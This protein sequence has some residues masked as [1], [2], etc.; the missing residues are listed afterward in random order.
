LSRKKLDPDPAVR[1]GFNQAVGRGEAKARAKLAK[2]PK[3]KDALFALT[4]SSGLQGD[5]AALI[6]KR[7]LLSLHFAKQATGWA[8]QLL[9]VDPACSDAHVATGFSKYI[10]GSMS[11]PFRWLVRMGGISG[12]KKVGISE[13]ELTAQTGHYLAPFARILLAI[14]Y[15]REKDNSHARELLASL[16]D[17]FP[18]NPLFAYEIAHLDSLH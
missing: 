4:L 5:Y 6:D 8:E 1:D 16:R 14:A 18:A 10:I 17:Q 7:N 3:D 12:D 9:A 11:A 2:N 13:L 15:V